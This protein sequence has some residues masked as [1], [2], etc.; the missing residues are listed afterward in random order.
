MTSSWFIQK[1]G[2]QHGPFS[3]EQL[4]Q[5]AASG[6]LQPGD[7][8]CQQGKTNWS[9]A[10][11]LP[12]LFPAAPSTGFTPAG[13][14]GGFQP[15]ASPQ[16]ADAA[17]A[18]P[19]RKRS[20]VE[21]VIYPTSFQSLLR[22]GAIVLLAS[23][24]VPWWGMTFPGRQFFDAMGINRDGHAS[25]GKEFFIG[26]AGGEAWKQQEKRFQRLLESGSLETTTI[27]L[28][29]WQVTAA[30]LAAACGGLILV[31][32]VLEA[33]VGSVR[34]FGWL[35][36]FLSAAVSAPVVF[37]GLKFFADCPQARIEGLTQSFFAGPFLAAGGGGLV[38]VGGLVCG[39]IGLMKR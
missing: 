28:W 26:H 33:L 18:A 14:Q 39:V 9:P 1:N 8:V 21:K 24:F 4:Q 25:R 23:L 11:T 10:G 30:K 19:R 15:Y 31:L 12:G 22:V 16:T 5:L 13:F 7:L 29:G 27:W 34:R 32:V 6:Q 38:I 17:F 20:A 36:W 35:F 37:L 3:A 2:Q